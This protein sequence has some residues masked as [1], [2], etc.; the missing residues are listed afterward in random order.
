MSKILE[1]THPNDLARYR[2]ARIYQDFDLTQL[3]NQQANVHLLCVDDYGQAQ[4]RCSLWWDDV[5]QMQGE[6]IGVIGHFAAENESGD[7]DDPSHVLLNNAC[8]R[9]KMEGCSRAVGPMDGNTWRHYRFVTEMGTQ[10]PF[11]LEPM[12]PLAWPRYWE[13]YGFEPLAQYSSAITPDLE[14]RDQRLPKLEQRLI[15]RGI[16]FRP[17]DLSNYEQELRQIYNISV[18]S[19]VNNFL[20]TPLSE[21]E[22]V[23]QYM[24]VRERV[25]PELTLLAHKAGIPVGFLFA[26]PDINEIQ[27]GEPS[28]TVIIKTVAVLPENAHAGLGALLVDKVQQQARELGFQRAIHALMYDGNVSRNISGHYAEVMRRYTLYFKAFR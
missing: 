19:F 13:N 18:V 16:R 26:I 23:A 15:E 3:V 22:F 10:A 27:R 7:E 2:H 8:F 5:P 12:N 24:K 4:A 9:L 1:V 6:K 21:D 20:Y 25:V 11:F 14:K 28:T 17:L